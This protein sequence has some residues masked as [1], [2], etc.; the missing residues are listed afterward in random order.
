VWKQ[1]VIVGI[2]LAAL[3]WVFDYYFWSKQTPVKTTSSPIAKT[4]WTKVGGEN[5]FDV[6]LNFNQV[7]EK[8]GNYIVPLLTN[9]IDQSQSDYKSAM[10]LLEVDCQQ[11]LFKMID[12]ANYT[13]L[14]ASGS[15]ARMPENY[16]NKWQSGGNTTTI[17]EKLN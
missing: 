12:G 15:S 9:M 1:G 6:Y 16:Y 11:S 3:I 17:C 2:S 4:E 10:L 14:W 13:E 5:D 7:K 8:N